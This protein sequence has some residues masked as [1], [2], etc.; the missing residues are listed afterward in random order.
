M[1]LLRL[2]VATL[3]AALL[4]APWALAAPLTLDQ[5]LGLALQQSQ[6]VRAAQA[7]AAGA[8]E[9]ARAAGQ[10]PDPMLGAGI[11]NLPVTGADRFSTTRESMTMKRL[12]ISQEWVS[13]DKRAA[14]S[15]AARALAEREASAEAA[16]AALVR[17]QTALAFIDAGYASEA[18][19]LAVQ[20]E[21]HARESFEAGRA[22]LGTAAGS[23]AEA[24]GLAAAR[25][26]AEDE[27][28]EAR[29][30]LAAAR[31]ALQRWTGP[32]ADVP[33]ALPLLGALASEADFVADHPDVRARQH[34]AEVARQEAALMA[35]NRRP[36]WTWEVSYG[37]RSGY[38]DL[39]SIGVSIPLPVA[40][41]ARQDRELAARQAQV[42]QADAAWAEAQRAARA[43]Y[44]GLASDA[45]RLQ[46]R[47]EHYQATVLAPTR[48]RTAAAAAAYRANQ[49]SLAMLFDARHAELETQRRWL[50]L[51][52]DLAKA[53][54]QLAFKPLAE[55]AA[56]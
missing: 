9:A 42:D 48:Q 2:R 35:R 40:P 45:Q 22:R 34:D 3:A 11:D 8:A 27:A 5:A 12:A 4:P 17:L 32:T 1:P 30:Q 7:G 16:A 20:N 56:R 13:A 26:Q 47:A 24:L 36:N 50:G 39:V 46:E 33:D 21:Q 41:A 38:P 31:L 55:G 54:A 53:R 29:Q 49:G 6:A 19:A 18:L 28:A 43:E 44:A 51:Q 37:Q 14:R 15:A 52:R 25:G 23:G 10:L